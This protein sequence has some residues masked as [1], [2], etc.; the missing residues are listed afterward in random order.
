MQELQLEVDTL[1]RQ[2]RFE[3]R[4]ALAD[5]ATASSAVDV[6]QARREAA[7]RNLDEVRARFDSGLADA[8]AMADA[9][10]QAYLAATEVAGQRLSLRL[11][12]LALLRATGQPLPSL[13]GSATR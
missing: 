2:V 13:A 4:T 8:L 1:G 5:L 7:E 9:T 12:E 11:A 3:I 6:A 10:E